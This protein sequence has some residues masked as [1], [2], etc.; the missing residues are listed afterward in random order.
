VKYILSANFDR[1][2]LISYL[3]RI[4][5]LWS[6][7]EGVGWEGGGGGRGKEVGVEG[8]GVRPII[9]LPQATIYT[10]TRSS[11]GHTYI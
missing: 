1:E 4:S 2:L 8:V 9:C 6:W 5:V 10:H 7:G 11:G 3:Y